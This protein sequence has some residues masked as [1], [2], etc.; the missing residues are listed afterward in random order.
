M[1]RENIVLFLK[2]LLVVAYLVAIF[3]SY[4][5][6][7]KIGIQKSALFFYWFVFM[8]AGA[9]FFNIRFLSTISNLKEEAELKDLFTTWG[10]AK[11]KSD[12]SKYFSEDD[13]KK[14]KKNFLHMMIFLVVAIAFL[15][16]LG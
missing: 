10:R 3:I 1:K 4:F 14:Y 9:T 12:P 15:F 11:V 5:I 6:F 8:G 16:V 2:I 7:K 13:Y